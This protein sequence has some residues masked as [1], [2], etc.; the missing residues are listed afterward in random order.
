MAVKRITIPQ[1]TLTAA[2][3]DRLVQAGYKA[4][5]RWHNTTTDLQQADLQRDAKECV[6]EMLAVL[7]RTT[8][9]KVA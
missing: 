8:G 3:I 5:S 9:Q 7:V 4:L 1:Q 2:D 6:G